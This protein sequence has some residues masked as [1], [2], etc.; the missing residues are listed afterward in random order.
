MHQ[1]TADPANHMAHVGYDVHLVTTTHARRDRYAPAVTI[2][3]PETPIPAF[4][5]SLCVYP[6]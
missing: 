3:T 1:Y 6:Q 2:H 5:C 4:L